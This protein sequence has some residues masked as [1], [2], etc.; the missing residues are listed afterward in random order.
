[1]I[2]PM[3]G[4]GLTG[5][6]WYQGESDVGVAGYA[7]RLGALFR[8]WRGQFRDSDLPMLVVALPRLWSRGDSAGRQRLG[9]LARRAAPGVAADRRAALVDTIDLGD[10]K[11]LHPTN[12]APV[13]ARLA[14]AS[15]LADGDT[16]AARPEIA[17]ATREGSEIV[18]HFKGVTGA[19]HSLSDAHAIGFEL[20]A[21]TQASCRYALATPSGSTV[22]LADDG[23][24]ATRVRYAWAD[25]PF[26]NLFDEAE[27][28]VGSFDISIGN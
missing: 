24:P 14:A 17:G 26:I 25:S 27:L 5:V 23:K 10:P 7:Q 19:L 28:P 4:F 6:A 18:L 13:G 2:A 3:G 20:C 8:G 21:G 12:K 16:R 11:N 1:M 9:S 22:R 15:I